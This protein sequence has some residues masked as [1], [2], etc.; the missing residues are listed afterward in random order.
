MVHVLLCWIFRQIVYSSGGRI[1]HTAAVPICGYTDQ[2]EVCAQHLVANRDS[3]RLKHIA[4]QIH[5]MNMCLV[6]SKCGQEERLS[7]VSC[8]CLDEKGIGGQGPPCLADNTEAAELLGWEPHQDVEQHV[9]R[10]DAR[11]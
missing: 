7:V 8:V 6:V 10:E 11:I 5:D 9:Q 1:K 2:I 3:Y 4:Y